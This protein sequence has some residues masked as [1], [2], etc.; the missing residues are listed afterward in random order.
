MD[1][2]AVEVSAC[3]VLYRI[4]F[5]ELDDKPAMVLI[6][7]AVQLRRR[8]HFFGELEPLAHLICEG[9]LTESFYCVSDEVDYEV[10]CCFCRAGEQCKD[11]PQR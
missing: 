5:H 9:C 11:F 6:V 8:I 7:K 10:L 2:R 4:L 1:R 3:V